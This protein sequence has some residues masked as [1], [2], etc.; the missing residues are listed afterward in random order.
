MKHTVKKMESVRSEYLKL[1][2]MARESEESIQKDEFFGE[3]KI[4][5]NKALIKLNGGNRVGFKQYI[6]KIPRLCRCWILLSSTNTQN[7]FKNY[8]NSFNFC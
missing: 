2:K 4:Y 3:S 7:Y 8:I 6:D 5:R 1:A